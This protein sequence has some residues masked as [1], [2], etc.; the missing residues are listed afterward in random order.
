MQCACTVLL[1]LACPVLQYLSTLSHKRHGQET[2]VN[3]HEH[4]D[5]DDDDDDDDE[6]V[7]EHINYI[8]N[9]LN[10]TITVY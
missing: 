2:R 5:D 4:D 7:T 9:Q 3:L 10:A 6:K 8:D 1:F